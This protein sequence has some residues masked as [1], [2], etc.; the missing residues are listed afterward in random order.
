MRSQGF[1]YLAAAAF[2]LAITFP[3]HAQTTAQAAIDTKLDW[4]ARA[5]HRWMAA[6]PPA[7]DVRNGIAARPQG[8]SDPAQ[9]PKHSQPQPSIPAVAG[10]V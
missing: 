5:A 4:H 2:G 1:A 6:P 7:G 9:R 3:A 10:A 8:V